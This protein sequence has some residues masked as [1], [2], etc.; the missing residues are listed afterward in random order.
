MNGFCV[1]N[2][3]EKVY[4]F[5]KIEV[6]KGEDIVKISFLYNLYYR[7][8]QY[9]CNTIANAL[10]KACLSQPCGLDIKTGMVSG[11]NCGSYGLK[12]WCFWVVTRRVMG[13]M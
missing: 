3:L 2:A 5:V 12:V 6:R 1:E 9:C 4:L 10:H 7:W 11:K 8:L 13:D